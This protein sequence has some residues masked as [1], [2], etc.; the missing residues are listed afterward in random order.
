M[1][2]F[3]ISEETIRFSNGKEI[4]ELEYEHEAD[5][6]EKVYADFLG[7]TTRV[8]TKEGK[9]KSIFQLDFYED[10]EKLIE[11]VKDQGFMLCAKDGTKV[12]VNCYDIQNGYYSSNLS[13]ILYQKKI[14]LEKEIK[15]ENM[16]HI[17]E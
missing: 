14:I 1:R 17:Y 5:C 4:L 8:L 15:D 16:I 13:V 10:V 11:E 3:H 12:L 7:I 2:I 6:C 9:D